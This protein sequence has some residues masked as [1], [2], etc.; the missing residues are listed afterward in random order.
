M[1]IGAGLRRS[2][3]GYSDPLELRLEAVHMR[4]RVAAVRV[5]VT[6]SL[7]FAALPAHAQLG[8]KTAEEWINS[9]ETPTRLNGLKIAETMKAL[10]LKPG[11][12]VADIGAG[13]GV[14]TRRMANAV[15]PG[16]TVY[17]VEV[18]QALLTHIAETATEEGIGNVVTVYGEYDDPGLPDNVDVALIYDVL[19]HIEHRDV[20]LKNLA[21]YLKPGGRVALV[22]FKPGAGDHKDDPTLQVTAEQATAWM[23]AA[24][25]KQLEAIDLA[26]DK[27][28]VIYGK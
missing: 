28:L 20:Y 21:G 1:V 2:I 7:L 12:S 13:S 17:A 15:K 24:G 5:A 9:L 11:Q 6:L 8:P 16:G 10:A 18:D 22:D 27:F 25:L 14:F 19:H 4:V 26:P 3:T 23:T